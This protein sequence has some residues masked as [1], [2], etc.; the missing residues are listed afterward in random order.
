[1]LFLQER[2]SGGYRVNLFVDF[3][4]L[5][6]SASAAIQSIP[7]SQGVRLWQ[8]PLI[9]RDRSRA[10]RRLLIQ[11][12]NLTWLS[13]P[14][15]A[16][17]LQLQGE[18]DKAVKQYAEMD[19]QRAAPAAL[20]QMLSARGNVPIELRV[21]MASQTTQDVLYFGGMCQLARSKPQPQVALDWFARYLES[22]GSCTLRADELLEPARL[23]SEILTQADAS[24]P[25]LGKRMLEKSP[26]AKALVKAIAMTLQE[27]DSAYAEKKEVAAAAKAL[28][29]RTETL[30]NAIRAAQG[31]SASFSKTLSPV[32]ATLPSPDL[33]NDKE[34][35][36]TAVGKLRDAALESLAAWLNEQLV[37]K[38]LFDPAVVK[39]EEPTLRVRIADLAKTPREQWN[40]EVLV[41]MNRLLLE[42]A[43]PQSMTFGR[44]AWIA[45]VL[46]ESAYA[47]A[48][49]SKVAEAQD[50][51]R[52]GHPLLLPIQR[53]ELLALSKAI[54]PSK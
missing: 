5:L 39:I 30:S 14:K 17:M 27:I 7:N 52:K 20:H 23:V 32:L 41:E 43:Y 40:A 49:Q 31:E 21:R 33:F 38:D 34:Q 29:E 16:R 54:A 46:R 51:L 25:N 12:I 2:L 10:N 42:S 48:M 3:D 24:T 53:A 6:E 37:R 26:A 8:Y 47:L 36:S 22:F 4:K 35:A 13:N 19:M 45:G 1:M 15:S 18:Y 9:V 11:S 50:L 28:M 44:P